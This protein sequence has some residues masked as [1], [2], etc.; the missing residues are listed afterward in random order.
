MYETRRLNKKLKLSLKQIAA[1][2]VISFFSIINVK[3]NC[4]CD[5]RYEFQFILYYLF[6]N[7]VE[8]ELFLFYFYL[9]KILSATTIFLWQILIYFAFFSLFYFIVLL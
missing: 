7:S 5:L 9:V 2:D 4:R 8:I 6:N 3:K 1:I